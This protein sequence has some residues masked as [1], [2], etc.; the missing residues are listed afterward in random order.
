MGLGALKIF[1]M[2]HG[3]VWLEEKTWGAGVTPKGIG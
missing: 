1:S 2:N 3:K